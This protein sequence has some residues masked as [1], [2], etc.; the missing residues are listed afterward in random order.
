MAEQQQSVQERTSQLLF[1]IGLGISVVV[2]LVWLAFAGLADVPKSQGIIWIPVLSFVAGLA[3]TWYVSW[4]GAVTF[5]AGF[6]GLTIIT[7]STHLG[8]TTGWYV[9]LLGIL[10]YHLG[11]YVL[12]AGHKKPKP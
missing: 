7:Y 11:H 5:T 8:L 10:A 12:V 2:I 4:Q 9:A 3:R 6:G 1:G